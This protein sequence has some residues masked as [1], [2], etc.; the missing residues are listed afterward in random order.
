MQSKILE[1]HLGRLRLNTIQGCGDDN[2]CRKMK[3]N[4]SDCVGMLSV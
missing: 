2:T 4:L 1:S 3:E